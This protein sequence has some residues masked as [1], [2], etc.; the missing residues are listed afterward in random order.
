MPQSANLGFARVGAAVP[1]VRV[2]DFRFNREQT[3]DLWK[4]A[5]E[6]GSGASPTMAIQAAPLVAPDGSAAAPVGPPGTIEGKVGKSDT[7]GKLLRKSGL[8]AGEAD[9]V[10]RSLAGVLDF[11][12]IKAGQPFRIERGPDGRVNLFELEL[13]TDGTIG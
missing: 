9:E 13:S 10:I 6:Q 2:V 4:K 3:R 1:P 11:K 12:S 7:L 5:D 8:S